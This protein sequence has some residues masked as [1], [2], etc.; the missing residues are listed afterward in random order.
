MGWKQFWEELARET[1]TFERTG[2]KGRPTIGRRRA[3][4]TEWL[5]WVEWR[6]DI[7]VQAWR[8]GPPVFV[9]VCVSRSV[10][11]DSL[12]PHGLQPARLLCPW[13][14]PGKNTGVGYIFFPTQGMNP[15]L[16]HYRQLLYPLSHLEATHISKWY[17]YNHMI[18]D[19]GTKV[20]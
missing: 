18:S 13:D 19:K 12:W 10:V 3:W 2:E 1:H 4:V 6:Q 7:E 11:S 8:S 9:Y 20:V 14:S 15:C 17:M 5:V 16:L